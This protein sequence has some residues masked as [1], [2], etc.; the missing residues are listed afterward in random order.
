VASLIGPTDRSFAAGVAGTVKAVEDRRRWAWGGIAGPAAFVGAWTLGG[1]LRHGYS[2]TEDAI[3]RLAEVGASTRPLM[4][5][6]LVAFGVGVPAYAVALRHRLDGGAWLAATATGLA[7][8][9]VA[10]LPLGISSSGDLLHGAA[11]TAGY[12]TL[13]AVPLLAV[14]P[15]RASGQGAAAAISAAAG[16]VSALSLAA[17]TLGTR[18]GLWQRAGLSIGDAWLVASAVAILVARENPWPRQ[19]RRHRTSAGKD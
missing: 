4:T 7:T 19:A 8:L 11:A 16:S 18:H 14:R 13:A 9:C 2:P 10:A 17:T 5:L 12:A 3:S 6:G 1:A 15:L